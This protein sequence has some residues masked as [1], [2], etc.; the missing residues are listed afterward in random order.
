MKYWLLQGNRVLLF[1]FNKLIVEINKI[2]LVFRLF[3]PCSA[4]MGIEISFILVL[5]T[6][7]S[8]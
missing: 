4:S 1:Y 7:N 6:P 5:L 2:S 8:L 3:N